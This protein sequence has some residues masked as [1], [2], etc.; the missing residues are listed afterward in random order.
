M[1]SIHQKVT[2]ENLQQMTQLT[3]HRL[4]PVA[5]YL[6]NDVSHFL[7]R[8]P[9]VVCRVVSLSIDNQNHQS[10]FQLCGKL[11]VT[12]PQSGQPRLFGFKFVLPQ[13][14]PQKAPLVFLDEPEKPEIV[15]MI[16]YLD[17]GN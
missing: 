15:E 6:K 13:D 8:N 1:A 3:D 17:K 11:R 12:I 4:S 14:Y 16:D 9:A 2:V 10:V 7:Q 5:G